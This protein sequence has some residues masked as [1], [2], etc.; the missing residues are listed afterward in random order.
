MKLKGWSRLR[1]IV[2]DCRKKKKRGVDAVKY[3]MAPKELFRGQM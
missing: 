1:K 3:F 2:T